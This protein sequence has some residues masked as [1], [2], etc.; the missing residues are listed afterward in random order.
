M[1][2]IL[3]LPDNRAMSLLEVLKN[4]S[5]VKV[6]TISTEKATFFNELKSSIEEVVLAKQGKI[7]LKSADELLNEL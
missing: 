4:I 5:F 3:D 2:V 6:E 1:K 7:K